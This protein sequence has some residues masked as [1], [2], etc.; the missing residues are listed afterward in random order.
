MSARNTAHWGEIVA[1]LAM[2]AAAAPAAAAQ[3]PAKGAQPSQEAP[4]AFQGLSQSRDQPVKIESTTLEVRDKDN[5]ATFSGNVQVTQGDTIMRCK[6]LVVF[7]DQAAPS[8]PVPA[9]QKKS[10]GQQIKKAEATGGVVVIQ[11]DQTATGEKGLF[12]MKSNTVTLSGN[13]VVTQGQ[14]VVRGETLFIDLTTGLSRVEA[15]KG[16]RTESLIMPSSQQ[17]APGS[18]PGNAPAPPRDVRPP[19]PGKDAKPPPR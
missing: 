4:G 16:K 19:G 1:V 7:Y 14:N 10:G 2:L 15:A 9:G 3:Q 5:K 8:A 12:D 6:T 17:N 11:K 18:A 13:V